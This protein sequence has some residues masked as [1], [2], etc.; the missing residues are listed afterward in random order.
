MELTLTNLGIKIKK[1]GFAVTHQYVITECG[2]Y[3]S[4][5]GY[6]SRY[7]FQSLKNPDFEH[8]VTELEQTV[9]TLPVQCHDP[10]NFC[11]TTNQ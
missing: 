10:V 5:G 3:V 7:T 8:E 4:S 2:F 9:F 11:D 6:V 1:S